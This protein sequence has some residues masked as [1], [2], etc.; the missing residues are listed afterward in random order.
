MPTSK[1]CT[2]VPFAVSTSMSRTHDLTRLSPTGI[3][4]SASESQRRSSAHI[5]SWTR[6]SA[7]SRVD[8][9]PSCGALGGTVVDRIQ[10]FCGATSTRPGGTP[11]TEKRVRVLVG[12]LPVD[13]MNS[14]S[15][16]RRDWTGCTE[17]S[18]GSGPKLMVR[19][20]AP[21]KRSVL[22]RTQYWTPR[23]DGFPL[24]HEEKSFAETMTTRSLNPRSGWSAQPVIVDMRYAFQEPVGS[25]VADTS[26]RTLPVVTSAMEAN[27]RP[28]AVSKWTFGSLMKSVE[29]T[30]KNV[31]SGKVCTSTPCF[32]ETRPRTFTI[33]M[34]WLGPAATWTSGG[35]R[36]LVYGPFVPKCRPSKEKTAT[37][38]F[39]LGATDAVWTGRVPPP[40]AWSVESTPGLKLRRLLGCPSYPTRAHRSHRDADITLIAPETARTLSAPRSPGG[41]SP[42]S[43][44][45]R[46]L[47]AA[48][49]GPGST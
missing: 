33:S 23:Y 30:P 19:A 45:S 10:R 6:L 34:T 46:T 37:A 29:G 49:R 3:H 11:V 40:P 13:T 47:R 27:Q 48:T 16:E 32:V 7:V 18:V 14:V 35:V 2:I 44:R 15:V 43:G 17:N 12:P 22:L 1:S 25:S 31:D 5:A 39:G 41:K 38:A 21:L 42:R 28:L 8:L 20:T 26:R 4:P 36:R 24:V 9:D